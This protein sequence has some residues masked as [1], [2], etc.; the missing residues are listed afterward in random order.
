LTIFALDEETLL[1]H[2]IAVSLSLAQKWGNVSVS[3]SFNQ[4]LTNFDRNLSDSYNFGL[5]GSAN[6]RLYRGLSFNV[7]ANYS[8]IKDQIYLPSTE[9]TR[10]EILL[11]S[12]Q[13]P[14][15]YSFFVNFGLTY[16]FGSIFN[17]VV[18]PRMSGGGG[19][20]QNIIIFN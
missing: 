18:N 19:I 3:A 16:R 6:V 13:L 7:F 12:V 17:N 2:F 5:F 8:R 14:T 15:G 20:Q 10:D 11:R 1:Q 4:M 9:A